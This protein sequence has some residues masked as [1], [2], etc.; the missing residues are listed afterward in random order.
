MRAYSTPSCQF[1]MWA[2]LLSLFSRVQLFATLQTIARQ[3]PLSMGFPRQEYWSGFPF[4]SPGDLP[5]PGT[6]PISLM[7]SA[8][9]G[10]FFTTSATWKA[11]DILPQ[12]IINC[13]VTQAI[14]RHVSWIPM[15]WL[16][17]KKLMH[18]FLSTICAN[19]SV[20]TNRSEK[21]H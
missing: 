7:S 13:S 6:E 21:G 17:M 5:N 19:L 16:R 9:A 15:T 1:Q 10:R 4:P 20:Q 3:A 14:S 12:I 2:C 8:M 11:Q 18:Q